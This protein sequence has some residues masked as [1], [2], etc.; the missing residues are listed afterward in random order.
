MVN[1]LTIR[2]FSIYAIAVTLLAGALMYKACNEQLQP[3]MRVTSNATRKIDTSFKES[4]PQTIDSSKAGRIKYLTRTVYKDRWLV[5]TAGYIAVSDTLQG[6]QG[7]EFVVEFNSKDKGFFVP[8]LKEK[9]DTTITIRDSI[10]ITKET[11]VEAKSS[12]WSDAA[13]IAG[14]FVGGVLFQAGVK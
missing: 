8:Y 7:T 1:I 3:A 9:A 11:Q 5:D 14:G 12:F 4:K 10:V 6:V 13:K 2:F